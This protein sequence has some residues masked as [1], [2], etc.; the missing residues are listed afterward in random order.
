VGLNEADVAH[1]QAQ[2]KNH[3]V[4][5]VFVAVTRKEV[6]VVVVHVQAVETADEVAGKCQHLTLHNLSIQI[7]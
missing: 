6:V 3:G 1:L 2:I 4:V 7:Q 5:A